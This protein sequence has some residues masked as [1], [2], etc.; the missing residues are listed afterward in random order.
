MIRVVWI[1]EIW[2]HFSSGVIKAR[3]PFT[4][5]PTNRGA[6][7]SGHSN[8]KFGDLVIHGLCAISVHADV[9]GVRV[10]ISTIT[11]MSIA[12]LSMSFVIALR[13]YKDLQV[14]GWASNII[15]L[16]FLIFMQTLSI[17]IFFIFIVLQQRSH[18]NFI[19][20]R[21][22]KSFVFKI[23]KIFQ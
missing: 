15:L 7:L 13:L 5:I 19:P 2:N 6:R 10:L 4:E 20:K 17:A 22:Y 16:I 3:I 21:D 18:Q 8:M 12:V 14:P 23:Q 1:S 9:L 11:A